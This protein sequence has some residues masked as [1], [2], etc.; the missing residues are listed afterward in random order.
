M[1][2]YSNTRMDTELVTLI[3]QQGE[4]VR[5][6]SIIV[7]GQTWLVFKF[8]ATPEWISCTNARG[9]IVFMLEKELESDLPFVHLDLFY[10]LR[11][12]NA[13]WTRNF[14]D[15]GAKKSKSEL[16]V[17]NKSKKLFKPFDQCSHTHSVEGEE[18]N[19]E[20]VF[21][22]WAVNYATMPFISRGWA[23]IEELK[24]SLKT[25]II[26]EQIVNNT[27]VRILTPGI[28]RPDIEIGVGQGY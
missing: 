22:E 20:N 27:D 3:A 19:N 14:T 1:I 18:A 24:D 11:T 4:P 7:E 6:T 2:K 5:Q 8:V 15:K 21:S 28:G 10:D 12:L 26:I 13:F 17:F 25:A 23:L 9:C 16:I